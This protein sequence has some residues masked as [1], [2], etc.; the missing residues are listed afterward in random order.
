MAW[1]VYGLLIPYK[2]IG[3]G[4]VKRVLIFS[5]EF[6][7]LLIRWNRISKISRS[8]SRLGESEELSWL[9]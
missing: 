9:F 7:K 3:K 4:I 2:H 6:D 1:A 8:T 5:R